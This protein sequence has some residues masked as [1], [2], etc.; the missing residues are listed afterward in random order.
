MIGLTIIAG[1][2]L[3]FL[4]MHPVLHPRAN[5]WQ[6]KPAVY[7]MFLRQ[8][9]CSSTPMAQPLQHRIIAG[10]NIRA[11]RQ[12]ADFTQEHLAEKADLDW[13]YISKIERGKENISLDAL[14]RIAK[15]LSVSITDLVNGA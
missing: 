10:K 6:A 1:F 12:K 5:Q 11:L 8:R 3:V 15:A 4:F 14:A 2:A 13:T 7:A 9:I